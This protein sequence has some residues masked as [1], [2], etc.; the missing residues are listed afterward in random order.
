VRNDT[1]YF[2]YAEFRAQLFNAPIIRGSFKTRADGNVE[3][4]KTATLDCQAASPTQ[5]L[6]G[7]QWGFVAYL[8]V[9]SS[10]HLYLF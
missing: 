9:D 10:L 7:I 4:V 3:E 1:C 5:R 2:A 6:K 8:C